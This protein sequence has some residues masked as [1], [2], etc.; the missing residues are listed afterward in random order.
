MNMHKQAGLSLSGFMV[1]AIIFAFGALLGFKLAPAY[2]EDATIKRHFKAIAKDFPTGTRAEVESAFG[3]RTEIDR[4]SAI[5]GKE[6]QIAKEGGVNVL[7]AQYTV[8]VPLM[9]NISAC[10]D[11]TPASR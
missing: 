10:M 3:K 9:H 2:V 1:W 8:R 5:T 7:S 6:I 4:I 11:F